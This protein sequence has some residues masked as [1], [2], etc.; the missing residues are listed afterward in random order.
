MSVKNRKYNL[1]EYYFD[2][3]NTANKAYILGMLY[4]D[5]T[6]NIKNHQIAIS[7][8]ERDKHILDDIKNEIQS[9][10]PLKFYDYKS[11]NENHSNQFRLTVNSK[12]M[13]DT[14][15]N[16]GVIPNKSLYLSFPNWLDENLYPHFIRGYMDG[17][18]WISKDPKAPR[19]EIVGTDSFCKSMSCIIFN[20]FGIKAAIRKRHKDSDT[21]TRQLDFGGRRQ[22]KKF[23]DWVYQDADM[24]L[25]RKYNIYKSIFLNNDINNS[26]LN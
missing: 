9:D 10:A 5:G 21:P 20:Q 12:H 18:G 15:N 25:E 7:L 16:L 1:D 22:V 26:L 24:C 19:V 13:S 11:K 6:N 17:D 14:L 4:A 3:I 8:Q 2:D 23:L